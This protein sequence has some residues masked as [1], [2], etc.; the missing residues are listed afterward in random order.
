LRLLDSKHT[1][2]PTLILKSSN[3]NTRV[4]STALV[5]LLCRRYTSLN[6]KCVTDMNSIRLLCF[7]DISAVALPPSAPVISDVTSS[8][9]RVN[10]EAPD[11]QL[12]GPPVTGY[13]L[14]VRTQ[15]SP[16]I[17]V[18]N[19]AI[20][21]TKVRVTK[22]QCDMRYEFRV[23][24]MNDN[25]LGECSATST[26]M[27]PVTENRPSQPGRPVAT[28]RGTSV[29][30]Q[31]SMSDETTQLTYVIRCRE[32]NTER[33]LW[34]ASTELIAGAT[35]HHTLNNVM[36]KSNTQY[37]FAVAACNTAGLGAFSHFSTSV[38]TPSGSLFNNL[39]HIF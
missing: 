22:L 17:N 19:I 15:H 20:T 35:I 5:S 38:K 29:N 26:A 36:L 4:L 33:T 30:L 1:N 8:S 32:A 24:A 2:Y 14:E 11:I 12:D 27:V 37:Q 39:Y 13:F 6:G 3:T 25:G 31:W 21:G 23:R 18:N 9:C 34:Y 28:V 7:V 16:W 10:Y